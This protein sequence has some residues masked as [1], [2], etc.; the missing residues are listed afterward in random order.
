MDGFDTDTNIIIIAATNRPDILD[1]A[2]LRPGRFDRR[3]TLDRP[4]VRGREA[5][6]KVHTRGKPLSGDVDLETLAKSTP[7]L[8]GADLENLVN[9]AAIFA[10]RKNRKS[11]GMRDFDEA[12]ERVIL[13]QERKSRIMTPR[14]RRIVAYHEAGHAILVHLLSN[15]NQLRKVT[16]IPRDMA[17]GVTWYMPVDDNHMGTYQEFRSDI[18]VAMGGR[19]AEQI[20]IGEITNGASG[21]LKNITQLARAMVTRW[22][23][24]QKLGMRIFGR[25]NEMVF[26]GREITE[27]RDYSEH[28][29]QQIDE[30]VRQIIE[31]EYAR[32]YQTLTDNRD[33]LDLIADRLLE[34]ETIDR[35]EF[36]RL[37]GEEPDEDQG[38]KLEPP[39]AA[40]A[41]KAVPPSN[42]PL[43][44]NLGPAPAPA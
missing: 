44:P 21:D 11:I 17:L 8:V 26:L 28:V 37:M 20:A 27:E 15:S 30:E 5:I 36:L 38:V 41:P 2:L 35:N 14:E 1:P 19:I 39:P 4:D 42:E 10:A 16:I 13:G 25:S 32:A 6:L 9:E 43:R 18:A 3:V 40:P 33:K 24:S 7:G 22:G 12:S 31:E 29:A 34:V 23:M